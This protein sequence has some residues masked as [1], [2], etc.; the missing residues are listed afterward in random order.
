MRAHASSLLVLAAFTSACGPIA[1]GT[2][3]AGGPEPVRRPAPNHNRVVGYYSGDTTMPDG[4]ALRVELSLDPDAYVRGR[5]TLDGTPSDFGPIPF[6]LRNGLQK[7]GTDT[8]VSVMPE[9]TTVNFRGFPTTSGWTRVYVRRD[10]SEVPVEIRLT[11]EHE[12]LGG[13]NVL[14]IVSPSADANVDRSDAT[15]GAL[16]TEYAVPGPKS[17][18]F[19]AFASIGPTTSTRA[20]SILVED[21]THFGANEPTLVKPLV[22]P[23]PTM[24][25][26]YNEEQEDG[27][28]RQWTATSGRVVFDAIDGELVSQAGTPSEYGLFTFHFEDLR[29]EPSNSVSDPRFTGAAGTFTLAFSGTSTAGTKFLSR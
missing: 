18:A 12:P 1:P 13:E 20:F 26:N 3:D 8:A 6:D 16:V 19:S 5:V 9:G 22:F 29:M 23:D 17:G 27:T 15:M 24:Q 7:L 2:S 21:V 14:S 11:R 28:I 4:R 10:G 25:L